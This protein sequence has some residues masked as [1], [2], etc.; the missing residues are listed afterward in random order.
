MLAENVLSFIGVHE[1]CVINQ[2][3]CCFTDVYYIDLFIVWKCRISGLSLQF[4]CNCV[5]FSFWYGAGSSLAN[6]YVKMD[7]PLIGLFQEEV[8]PDIIL[9]FGWL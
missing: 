9:C 3:F 5:G 1:C 4:W 2:E 6:F 7:L 8:C